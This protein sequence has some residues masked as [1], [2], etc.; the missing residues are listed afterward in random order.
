MCHHFG[1][2]KFFRYPTVNCLAKVRNVLLDIMKGE[3]QF[4]FHTT[5][6]QTSVSPLSPLPTS[7]RIRGIHQSHCGTAGNL[8]VVNHANTVLNINRTLGHLFTSF[9]T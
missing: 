5:S 6:N 9:E 4:L 2:V 3:L 7:Q 1:N 8:D